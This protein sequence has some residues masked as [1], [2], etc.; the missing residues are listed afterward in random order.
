[1]T[2]TCLFIVENVNLFV[3][4]G[5][6]NVQDRKMGG[7][8]LEAVSHPRRLKK[9]SEGTP[10]QAI[11][12]EHKKNCCVQK[13]IYRLFSNLAPHTFRKGGGQ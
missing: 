6:I 1:M 12:E 10:F 11:S 4:V 7:G 13:R 5:D 2:S 8:V 9:E 3:H